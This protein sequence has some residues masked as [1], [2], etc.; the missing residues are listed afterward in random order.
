MS[1]K[2]MPLEKSLSTKSLTTETKDF[3]LV[4]SD[5]SPPSSG[6]AIENTASS[7][8]LTATFIF[9]NEEEEVS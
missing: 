2:L 1:D 5:I 9:F 4:Q 8:S 7:I 6:P 3:E